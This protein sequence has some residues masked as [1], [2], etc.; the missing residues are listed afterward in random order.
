MKM[1]QK[2]NKN[3][4]KQKQRRTVRTTDTRKKRRT[5]MVFGWV[6]CRRTKKRMKETNMR[7]HTHMVDRTR[8]RKE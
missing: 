7:A 4:M 8:M 6:S 3:K 5:P 1:E 2:K